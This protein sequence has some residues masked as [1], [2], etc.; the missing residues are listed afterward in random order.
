[1]ALP[2]SGGTI[3]VGERNIAVAV[4]GVIM[5]S[6]RLVLLVT[7]MIAVTASTARAKILIT[8]D[9]ASQRMTVAVDGVERWHWA[10]STGRRGRA[11]P[12]GSYT[13]FRMEK[14]HFSKEWDDAP[15]PYS[16]FFT[17]QGHAIHGSYEIKR[18]GTP[19]S[20][21][22]VRLHPDNAARL[23][24]LVAQQGVTNT[25]VVVA[26]P[27]PAGA[28]GAAPRRA[29]QDDYDPPGY[30]PPTY[31]PAYPPVYQ[32]PAPPPGYYYPQPYPAYPRDGYYRPY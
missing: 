11:T 5:R 2:R 3:R 17:R 31:Q 4:A 32:R 19:A 30:P 21:G 20:A 13:A 6:L 23:F 8:I 25:T 12:S 16:I 29:P 22:C 28:P 27:E 24:A 9:K 14:D 1:M 10:V 18:L 15:M 7:A 26:G